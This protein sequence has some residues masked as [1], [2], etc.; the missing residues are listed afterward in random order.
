M[1]GIAVA[2]SVLLIKNQFGSADEV[3]SSLSFPVFV[4]PNNGGSSI[5]MSKVN[6]AS[7][8]LGAAI[9]KAF[10]EDDQVLV[11]E[12][13]QG[14]EFTVG[15]FR[16]NGAITVLPITEVSTEKEFFD[17]EAKYQGKSTEVTP[18]AIEPSW[19]QKI[20]AAAR[21]IYE[22]FNCSGVV[23]IDFIYNEAE[24][25]P[26]MLEI[27]TVPGQSDASIIPQQVRALGWSLQEFYSRLLE[28]CMKQG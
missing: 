23:R 24:N 12:M 20:E 8:E 4:K 3:A 25:K 14:R 15:V 16:S 21:R 28:E 6:A 2:K 17:F 13:I 7:E 9:E 18:A 27:N 1:S 11:E 19:Q 10:K 26:Y 22:V 5:G